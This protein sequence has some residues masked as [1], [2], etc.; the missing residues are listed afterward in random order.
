M[1]ITEVKSR[2]GWQ[3]F[4]KV[5][6]LIYQDDP[7]WIAPLQG[8]I[9]AVFNP[10]LNEAFKNGEAACFVLQA[11]DGS[12]LGRIAAFIDHERNEIQEHP[13]GGIGFFECVNDQSCAFALFE[14]AEQWLKEK[15]AEVIDGPINFGEREKFWGLLVKGFD[16][17]LLQEN[18]N[19]EYYRG[20]F[21]DWGFLPFEQIL[22]FKG[23]S[24][25]IPVQRFTRVVDRIRRNH[26]VETLSLDYSNLPKFTQDFC[27]IYNAAFSKY[28]HFKPIRPSQIEKILKEAKPVADPQVMAITYFDDRPAAFCALLPDI[29]ELLR[30]A[31]GKLNWWKIPILLW[32]KA[33]TKQFAAKGIGFGIHPDFQNKGAYPAILEFMATPRNMERYPLMVL[34]TV[35]AHNH[36]AV[37]VYKKL[38]VNVDRIHVAYRK[39]LKEDISIVPFEFTENY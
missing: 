9:E 23:K 16:P 37:S 26:K 19:P 36:E 4:H 22:T 28:G 30:F 1:N 15:G 20:F 8:D 2:K 38:G 7:N 29:N 35:R 5:P 27:E 24:K 31:R 33:R 11:D 6:H 3:A 13:I 18:Y 14:H 10:K 34:T 21:E 25:D 32:K 17:P 39:P 12:L